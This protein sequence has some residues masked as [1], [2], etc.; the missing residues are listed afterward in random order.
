MVLACSQDKLIGDHK[1]GEA[2]ELE[3]IYDV[4]GD[5]CPS[6]SKCS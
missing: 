3:G 6:P 4:Q 5:T 1:A 2:D